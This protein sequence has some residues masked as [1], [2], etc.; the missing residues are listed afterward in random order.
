MNAPIKHAGSYWGTKTDFASLMAH[1]EKIGPLLDKNSEDNEKLG[2]L[3]E[4]TFE[5]LKPL[6][7]SHV[8]AG[9]DIGGAQLSPTQGLQLIEAVTYHSGAAGW[10]SMVHTCIGAM[11]AAFLPDTAI[12]RL[13]G[14]EVDNRFSGQ[15]TPTGMLKKVDGGYRL[16]GKWSYASGIYHATYTHTAALLDDGNG[17]PAKDENGDVIVLCAHAPVED[18][19]LL[20]NWNVLGLQATGS[21]DYAAKDVFIPDDMVF[22]I[23]TAEPACSGKATSSGTISAG[24]KPACAPPAP[25]SS[26]SGARSRRRS[27]RATGCR[28]ARSVWCIWQNRKCTRPASMP[29]S[30]S[31]GRPAARRCATASC[32]A[33]IARC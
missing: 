14:G 25:S 9:E 12:G 27:R 17:Q 4:E 3:N 21:I 13:F 29:A 15:G 16:N 22:P 32:S 28:P 18:H 26:R 23:L 11:S 7:M 10:I 20:G 8:F 1:V 5:A 31:T 19:D 30:S 33:S 24:Q 6:R 2:R